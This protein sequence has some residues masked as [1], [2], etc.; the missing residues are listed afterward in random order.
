MTGPEATS[1]QRVNERAEKELGLTNSKL[2]KD[3]MPDRIYWMPFGKPILIEWKKPGE[4]P[5]KRQW[6]W[7]YFLRG[8]QYDV[9][10]FDN[11]QRAFEYL[12]AA[13]ARSVKARLKKE[14]VQ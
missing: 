7:I 14:G 6:Y 13:V 10:W 11:E 8:L 12:T 2:G 9:Q 1:E 5:T 3:G 4:Q